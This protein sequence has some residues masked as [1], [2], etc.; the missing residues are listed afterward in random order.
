LLAIIRSMAPN[1]TV[2]GILRRSYQTRH[3]Q[4]YHDVLAVHKSLGCAQAKADRDRCKDL[5]IY[6]FA[7][8]IEDLRTSRASALGGT[9]AYSMQIAKYFGDWSLQRR[10]EIFTECSSRN[11]RLVRIDN[12]RVQRAH[13]SSGEL[14]H[15][16]NQPFGAKCSSVIF[17]PTRSQPAQLSLATAATYGLPLF[18]PAL[19]PIHRPVGRTSKPAGTAMG[20]NLL[21][22][23][24]AARGIRTPDP[25][26]TNV[27]HRGFAQF[28]PVSENPLM[29]DFI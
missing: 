21:D 23:I 6:S 11:G 19:V 9:F 16:F 12:L 18:F 14:G 4:F 26:I 2:G 3:V 10:T 25:V 22:F 15:V 5:P 29:F 7:P 1:M 20:T 28:P 24:G 8:S 17:G 13:S 27:G